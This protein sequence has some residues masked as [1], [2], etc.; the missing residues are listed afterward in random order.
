MI[1]QPT[2]G[3]FGPRGPQYTRV[4]GAWIF[5]SLTPWNFPSRTHTVYFNPFASMTLPSLFKVLPHAEGKDGLMAWV[6]GKGLDKLFGLAAG[7]PE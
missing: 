5:H 2:G 6:E 7:W 1:R 3:W 4:S